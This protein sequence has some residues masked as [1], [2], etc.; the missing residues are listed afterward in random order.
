MREA[1]FVLAMLDEV[2]ALRRIRPGSMSYGRD[3]VRD[4]GYLEVVR[5]AMQRRA[6]KKTGA[7]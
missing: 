7:E 4:R 5:L 3:P 6:G 2:L 1:G